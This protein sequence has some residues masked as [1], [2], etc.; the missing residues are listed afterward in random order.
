MITRVGKVF[1]VL[2][3]HSGRLWRIGRGRGGGAVFARRRAE[4]VPRR[5]FTLPE[6]M[7][8]I[9]IVAALASI[10]WYTAQDSIARNRMIRVARMLQSDIQL[11]RTM[12]IT[13][14]RETRLKL[15]HADSALDPGAAQQGEWLLQVGDRSDRSTE[16]DT[17]PIN[18]PGWDGVVA[19]VDDEG[20][21]SLAPGGSKE[22]PWISL[23]SWTPLAGPGLGNADCVVFSPR[24]WVENPP[25][26]FRIGY[27]ALRI[28]NKRAM[29]GG[30]TVGDG[31]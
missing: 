23:A 13:T 16:W 22:A 6:V 31:E 18:E 7:M 4:L 2:I 20:E 1:P 27:I 14:N 5:G 24:G 8:A 29:L 9:A 12:A 30:A 26:D 10:G 21:R 15:V 19:V 25:G 3:A 17:L 28:V 11:L